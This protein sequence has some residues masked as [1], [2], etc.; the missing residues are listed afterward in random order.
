MVLDFMFMQ[1][2]GCVCMDNI[3]LEMLVGQA[4]SS[5]GGKLVDFYMADKNLGYAIV[6]K[7]HQACR[8]KVTTEDED[9]YSVDFL[10]FLN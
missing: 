1:H 7:D 3:F 2:K 5:D 10:G 8:Y 6:I 9:N 4:I